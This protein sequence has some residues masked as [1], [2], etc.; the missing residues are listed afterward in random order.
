MSN[1]RPLMTQSNLGVILLVE[2]D[3]A[4]SNRRP[5]VELQRSQGDPKVTVRVHKIVEGEWKKVCGKAEVSRR[6]METATREYKQ[7]VALGLLSKCNRLGGDP[8]I[9][10][11]AS[12]GRSSTFIKSLVDKRL[13]FIL[14]I[15]PSHQV[16]CAHRGKWVKQKAADALGGCG[17]AGCSNCS[18]Q[19]EIFH[20]IFGG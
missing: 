2:D 9:V 17:V 18:P 19:R 12:Y 11:G 14:E 13:D 1:V 16:V 3:S 5:I 7:A 6:Q 10:A 20:P 4:R 8:V 15:R